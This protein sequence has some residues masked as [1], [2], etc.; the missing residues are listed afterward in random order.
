M[1]NELAQATKKKLAKDD[2]VREAEVDKNDKG[3]FVRAR[4]NDRMDARDLEKDLGAFPVF[5]KVVA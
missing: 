5:V 4:A 3:V 2:R 1:K